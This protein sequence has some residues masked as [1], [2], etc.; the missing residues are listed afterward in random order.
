[1]SKLTTNES[2]KKLLADI[3]QNIVR[4]QQR[5]VVAVNQEM[6]VLYWKIGALILER[7]EQD[8]W[9]AKV[10]E[11]LSKDLSKTF[12]NMK[13][14]SK[15]NLK[16]MRQFAQTYADFPIG[17]AALDQISW[18]HNITLLQKCND[19]N[20]RLW[21][22]QKALQHGWSRNVMLHQIESQ[23]YQRQGKA[24]TNFSTQLPS[25]QSD[26]A[27]QAL[28]DPYWLDFLGLQEEFL[29]RELEDAIVKHITTFLLELGEGF[30]FVGRQYPLNVSSKEYRIDLLFY[31]LKLH[32]Y[33]AIDLKTGTFQ[34]E[35][36]GKMNFYLSA[37]DDLVKDSNDQTS[38]G[39]I[40][41]KEKDTFTAKYALKDIN[42]PIGVSTY[43][44]SNAL[45]ENFKSRLPSIEDLE[46]EL[47]DADL[48]KED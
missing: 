41:C 47:N 14:F 48:G 43:E 23:L 40:L 29:E 7:Q 4:S 18:Y 25:P 10:I 33:M 34:P 27:Q 32:C 22:A 39:L 12:P 36:A 24:I 37:L 46:R 26:M 15:T 9:G 13:G 38:I 8:G 31:H 6:L 17:Q 30:A 2:Y 20:E 1:M 3:K 42:K 11:Q 16:Y 5:A 21:Y 45:P 28:K 44:T 35:Y 19:A